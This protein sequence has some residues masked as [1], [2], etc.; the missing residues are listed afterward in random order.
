[1]HHLWQRKYSEVTVLGFTVPLKFANPRKKS[2]SSLKK[3]ATC[4]QSLLRD[5]LGTLHKHGKNG[6]TTM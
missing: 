5:S 2:F 1:M 3:T 4:K 6:V